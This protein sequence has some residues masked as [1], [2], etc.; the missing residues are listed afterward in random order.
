MA[1]DVCIQEREH[2]RF[3]TLSIAIKFE[4]FYTFSEKHV[5][6]YWSTHEHINAARLLVL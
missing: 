6:H 5:L 3:E 1:Y 4:V 2:N